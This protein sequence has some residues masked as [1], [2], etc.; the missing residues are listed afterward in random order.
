[1]EL[2][3][4]AF[5]RILRM[6]AS[7]ITNC[8][9]WSTLVSLPDIY[10][11]LSSSDFSLSPFMFDFSRCGVQSEDDRV[12]EWLIPI[13]KSFAA[14]RWGAMKPWAL[15]YTSDDLASICSL[16]SSNET[17]CDQLGAAAPRPLK[18]EWVSRTWIRKPIHFKY[19]I[20]SPKPAW[21]RSPLGG[22]QRN[23]KASSSPDFKKA[24]V[25]R[26]WLCPQLQESS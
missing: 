25:G 1:M 10:L 21:L 15:F 24:C 14:L 3:P 11:V 2:R 7:I 22:K 23:Q 4:L 13:S 16:R 12:R 8:I 9:S 17:S 19:L 18:G 5:S 20:P 26:D 6:F